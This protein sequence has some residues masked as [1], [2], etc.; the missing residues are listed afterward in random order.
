MN[1]KIEEIRR[2]ESN[3]VRSLVQECGPVE[4][5]GHLWAVTQGSVLTE[6]VMAYNILFELAHTPADQRS[7]RE[8]V[9]GEAEDGATLLDNKKFMEYIDHCIR[10]LS[11]FPHASKVCERDTSLADGRITLRAG[12]HVQFH[13]EEL[14]AS[15]ERCGVRLNDNAPGASAPSYSFGFGARQCPGMKTGRATVAYAVF[16]TMRNRELRPLSSGQQ[17]LFD[18]VTLRI[19]QYVCGTRVELPLDSDIL[20]LDLGKSVGEGDDDDDN[21]AE[22]SPAAAGNGLTNKYPVVVRA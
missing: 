5:R 1:H 20:I 13:F 4:S 15:L 11:F 9:A 12:D 6:S 18:L 2:Q 10:R 21:V 17:S 7:V 16:F 19:R 3:F 14:N 22:C 8:M